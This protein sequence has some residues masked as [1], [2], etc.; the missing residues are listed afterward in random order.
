M[1]KQY[2]I[3]R[4]QSERAHCLLKTS[5]CLPG[6]PAASGET[7]NISDGGLLL[8]VS[9]DVKKDDVLDLEISLGGGRE[10][11]KTRARVVHTQ[12]TKT[13]R[14]GE[15]LAGLQ[16][17][18][19]NDQQQEAIGRKIWEQILRESTKFGKQV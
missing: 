13:S 12:Q 14:G 4:R 3:E 9:G 17:L 16:F 2:G 10:P 1:K 7:R 8:M 15:D 19:L 11:L 6:G 5:Y 18:A